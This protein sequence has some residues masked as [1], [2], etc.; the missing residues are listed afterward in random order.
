MKKQLNSFSIYVILSALYVLLNLLIPVSKVTENA[1]HL[2][3]VQVRILTFTYIL[4]I[5]G[6]WFAAFY[7]YEKL[8]RYSAVLKNTTEGRGFAEITKGTMW[9]A[10]GLAL[11]AILSTILTGIARKEPN[12]HS[13]FIIINNYASLVVSLGAFTYISSGTRRL[14][15]SAKL[16]P[17]RRGVQGLMLSFIMLGVFYCYFTIHSIEAHTG[18]Q[19]PFHLPLWLILLTIIVPYLY[20]WFMGLFAAY[21]ISLY[22]KNVKGVLY[23]QALSLLALGISAAIVASIIIQYVTS[24]SPRLSHFTLGYLLVVI[25]LL[26][27]AYS[28]GYILIALGANKLKKI[29]EV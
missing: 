18:L 27:L 25:Y 9:L 2:S 6:I 17:T 4:P 3:S 16:H 23:R 24:L 5:L 28:A 22:S 29:E 12:W 20:A 7:G 26:L 14:T 15:D 21:E 1:Y 13:A 19:N 8:R 11:S 10:W